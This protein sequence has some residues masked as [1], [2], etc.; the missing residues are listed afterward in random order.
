M[1]LYSNKSLFLKRG[2]QSCHNMPTPGLSQWFSRCTPPT[3]PAATVSSGNVLEI[4]V[5]R[6]CPRPTEAG[7]LEGSPAQCPNKTYRGYRCMLMSQNHCSQHCSEAFSHD[8]KQEG[9]EVIQRSQL[10]QTGLPCLSSCLQPSV[11]S[12]PRK[13]RE[14]LESPKPK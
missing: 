2:D 13:T 8:L 12:S 7:A 6:A 1:W 5:L 4:Q 14:P 9:K 3:Q 10:P 11:K